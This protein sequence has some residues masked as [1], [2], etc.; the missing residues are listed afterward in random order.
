MLV[1]IG[2]GLLAAILGITAA[3]LI[4]VAQFGF[5][6]LDIQSDDLSLYLPV[7]LAAV[8]I[9]AHFLP[10]QERDEMQRNIAPY[11]PALDAVL[12]ELENMPETVLVDVRSRDETV[13]IGVKQ[14][15]F[16][17]RVRSQ[18]GER[19]DIGFPVAGFR[20]TLGLAFN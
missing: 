3:G 12:K 9:G 7:P 6:S 4:A 5:V 11:R 18:N 10:R 1:K 20:K 19:V 17:C 2:M 14:G 13:F 8:G 16:E 15:R